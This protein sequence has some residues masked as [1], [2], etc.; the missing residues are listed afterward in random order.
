MKRLPHILAGTML[1]LGVATIP[2][3]AQQAG[4]L[5]FGA[6]FIAGVFIDA[7]YEGDLMAKGDPSAEARR[8]LEF[9]A[10]G[11]RSFARAR[12]AGGGETDDGA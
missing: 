2:A 6:I 8:F 11:K 10:G 5:Y 9:F 12:R 7:S 3:L 1:S 4:T